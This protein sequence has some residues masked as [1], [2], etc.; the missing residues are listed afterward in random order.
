MMLR[1]SLQIACAVWAVILAAGAGAS[2]QRNRPPRVMPVQR[3][4]GQPTPQERRILNL[5][6]RWVARLQQMPPAQQQ[7][8]LNNNA[9][10]RELPPQQQA[11]IRQRLQAFNN[12]SPEQRQAVIE[13]ERVW[14]QMSPQ[15]QR[16]I[17]ETLQ[18][19]WQSM[20]P[21]RRQLLLRKLRDLRGLNDAQRNDKIADE[22]FLN[23]LSPDE[24]QMLHELSNLRIAGP[25]T[26]GD[27]G[28]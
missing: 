5:P 20:P 26:P 14:E 8:F 27:P 25:E 6:S 9:R 13:R 12:L 22:S 11:M 28:E 15:Q 4:P 1:K 2:A 3:A 24:R 17:R 19:A 18:P 16:Y 21:P 10:F 7:R 23:G